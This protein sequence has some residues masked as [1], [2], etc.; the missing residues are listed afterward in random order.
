VAV[1]RLGHP[2]TKAA[3]EIIQYSV[4]QLLLVAVV[5][6]QTLVEMLVTLAVQV[7]AEDLVVV[8]EPLAI[9]HLQV[10]AKE[11]QAVMEAPTQEALHMPLVAV[12]V[13][14]Q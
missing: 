4:L 6:D 10:Q 12:A 13:L 11:I 14:G 1:V 3:Q 5:V 8:Q 7:V 9:R 2:E